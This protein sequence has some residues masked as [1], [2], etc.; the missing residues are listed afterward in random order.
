MNTGRS[1]MIKLGVLVG[2][3]LSL[4]N[5]G[6]AS[7]SGPATIEGRLSG[8][9]VLAGEPLGD[10]VVTLFAS[11][12]TRREGAIG[13][14]TATTDENG[15]FELDYPRTRGGVGILYLVADRGYRRVATVL[16]GDGFPERVVLNELTTVATAYVM[17]QF[18]A[19]ELIGGN[20]VG[21][22]NSASV[23]R[24]L[25]HLGTGASGEVISTF[26]NGDATDAFRTFNTLGN[27]LAAAAADPAAFAEARDLAAPPCDP[28]PED[29]LALAATLARNPGTAPRALLELG[30]TNELYQPA[31]RSATKKGDDGPPITWTLML[32]YGGDP[33]STI[34]GP[35]FVAIDGLG[36]IWVTNNFEYAARPT[37]PVCSGTTLVRLA[38]E[39]TSYGSAPY[40]GGGI[41]G[42]GWGLGFDTRDNAWIGNFGFKGNGATC[43]DVASNSV[44]VIS[45]EGEPLS[46]GPGENPDCDPDEGGFCNGGID[47]PQGVVSDSVNTIWVANTCGGSLTRIPDGDPSGAVE[48]E[49]VPEDVEGEPAPFGIAID[50]R[51]RAWVT[52]NG[53]S[54]VYCVDPDGSYREVVPSFSIDFKRPLG[55]AMDSLGNAWVADSG[56][57]PIADGGNCTGRS[58]ELS[59]TESRYGELVPDDQFAGIMRITPDGR[60]Q[61]RYT[62]GGLS[63]PWGVA[64]DG[65]DHV[66]VADFNGR[67]VSQFCGANPRHWPC[68]L[69]VGDPISPADGY[70]SDALARNVA[71]AVDQSGN[72]WLS[73]NFLIDCLGERDANPGGRTMVQ[74]LGI[75]SPVEGPLIGPPRRPAAGAA[76]PCPADFDGNGRVNGGDLTR[77]LGAWG[78]ADGWHDLAGDQVVG[79]EDLANLLDAWG[80]CDRFD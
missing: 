63:I 4:V 31:L 34:D 10:A 9:V 76:T 20:Q 13:L 78:T 30:S 35:G 54:T 60:I 56:I 48:I 59:G 73:N 39:G 24:N 71:V 29:L 65:D 50:A 51:D 25:V 46:P 75:A 47:G 33:S 36:S 66:W 8:E 11:G 52:D 19:G 26:P 70:R 3:L 16:G 45:S 5:A 79:P 40:S 74:F 77:L 43:P 57:I 17:N 2:S 69:E 58:V 41:S 62:G 64:I 6:T 72:V 7:V 23:F 18:L 15:E 55:N 44:S 27:I 37:T 14:A 21:L 61:D 42:A 67:R 80:A 53:A 32:R 12:T 68:G 38:P 1:M 49:L 28:A 22:G